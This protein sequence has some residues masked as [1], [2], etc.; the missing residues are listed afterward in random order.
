MNNK[1]KI[2]ILGAIS[3][4][5]LSGCGSVL[6]E[7]P[8]SN[9][10]SVFTTKDIQTRESL[11]LNPN[12]W[13]LFDDK[14]LNNLID[15][16]LEN[17]TDLGIAVLNIKVAQNALNLIELDK[18]PQ[19]SL[20]VDL[21]TRR[22]FRTKERSEGNS[23]HYSLNYEIDLW[24]SLDNAKNAKEWSLMA[25][26]QE[27]EST[28]LS[29]ISSII[30][31][32]YQAIY[33]DE[34]ISMAEESVKYSKKLLSITEAKFKVGRLSGLELSQ[35]KTSVIQQEYSLN[36][37]KQNY[38]E[39]INALKALLNLNPSQDFPESVAIPNKM[40]PRVFKNIKSD[41]PGKILK[42]RPDVL[43]AQMRIQEA[44][45]DV[46]EREADFYPKITLTTS[47]GNS[48]ADLIRFV[49]NPIGSL[50]ASINFPILDYG[51]NKENLRISENKYNI[52][53]LE[54]QKALVKA[55][56]EVE[57]RISFYYY[58]KNN[59]EKINAVL[60][61]KM[62]IRKIY[63]VRYNSGVAPLQDLLDAQQ[64]ERTA[65]LNKLK[66]IY[67]LI[68]SESQVYQALGGKYDD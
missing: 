8:K 32:Y 53:A 26:E 39:N 10:P 35:A 31:L 38:F 4:L 7:P 46:K 33:L 54:Y 24:N 2:S 36:E 44:F 48:T 59:Y 15:Y 61:E 41:I 30:S 21:D 67:N 60:K 28:K 56:G 17:N 22:N 6:L 52:Y 64:D 37:Y 40:P 34:T 11:N 16:A 58:N 27:K 68:N 66:H 47:L 42:N 3:A 51:R 20:G 19:H 23:L 25:T 9:I 1:F 50:A 62:K 13:K 18:Y 14:N 29:L 65:Y 57:N 49:S 12:W 63:D 5:I 45:Y 55:M 43:A